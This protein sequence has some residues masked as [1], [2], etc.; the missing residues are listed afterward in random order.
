MDK[1]EAIK[2]LYQE[3]KEDY[4]ERSRR[5]AGSWISGSFPGLD[6]ML[7]YKRAVLV[8][9]A[10]TPEELEHRMTMNDMEVIQAQVN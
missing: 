2:R 5:Y 3:A 10:R 1:L 7:A 8:M 6:K 4:E 9:E